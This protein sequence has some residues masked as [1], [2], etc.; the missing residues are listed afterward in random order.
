MYVE[1]KLLNSADIIYNKQGTKEILKQKSDSESFFY[2][3]GLV[4]KRN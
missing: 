2:R 1:K 3:I 4:I